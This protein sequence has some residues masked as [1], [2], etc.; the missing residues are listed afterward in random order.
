[1]GRCMK[2][3]IGG[4]DCWAELGVLVVEIAIMHCSNEIGAYIFAYIGWFGM[5]D[6]QLLIL[7][8]IS[9]VVVGT[10]FGWNGLAWYAR[11]DPFPLYFYLHG[12]G[13]DLPLL[14]EVTWHEKN[15]GKVYYL[16]P[17]IYLNSWWHNGIW[18]WPLTDLA[19]TCWHMLT[20]INIS[21]YGCSNA[22]A[23]I[24]TDILWK[25]DLLELISLIGNMDV[26]L[27]YWYVF[28]LIC[29]DIDA[30]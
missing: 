26:M 17:G 8:E 18:I 13:R 22:W 3:D 12:D 6:D 27:G 14:E 1:M 4:K 21:R 15:H 25:S 28:S 30:L 20:H 10:C 24:F 19:D 2:R 5:H 11:S 7:F 29:S 23:A 9:T 16:L